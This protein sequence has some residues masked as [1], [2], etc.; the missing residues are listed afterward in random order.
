MRAI[1]IFTVAALGL[2]AAA[3]QVTE[4]KNNHQTS[5]EFNDQLATNAVADVGNAATN[6]AGTIAADAKREAGKV[7]IKIKQHNANEATEDAAKNTTTTTTTVTTK[8][9]DGSTTTTTKR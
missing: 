4:D 1:S 8:N 2:T 9:A 7:D 3:C 6:I 5:V